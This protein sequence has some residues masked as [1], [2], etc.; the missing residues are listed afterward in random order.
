MIIC[1]LL[2]AAPDQAIDEDLPEVQQELVSGLSELYQGS[3]E[4]VSKRGK[5]RV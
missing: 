5:K 1:R 2:H 3:Q 4:T